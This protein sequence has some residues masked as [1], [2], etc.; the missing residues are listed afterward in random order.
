M[1]NWRGVALFFTTL[2]TILPTKVEN[3]EFVNLSNIDSSTLISVVE[4]KSVDL[5]RLM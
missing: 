3:K 1:A 5:S 4:V 2:A